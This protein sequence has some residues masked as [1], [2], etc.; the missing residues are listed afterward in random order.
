[1]L[2]GLSCFPIYPA[3]DPDFKSLPNCLM[4]FPGKRS[5]C[6]MRAYTVF[7]NLWRL[8]RSIWFGEADL[9]EC[10]ILATLH[11]DFMLASSISQRVSGF[12][13]SGIEVIT[14]RIEKNSV[15]NLFTSGP[16]YLLFLHTIMLFP[17]YLPGKYPTHSFK[18]ATCCYI[19]QGLSIL[20]LE[21]I[22]PFLCS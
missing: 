20:S 12:L 3:G 2:L 6:H 13:I 11:S 21:I 16:L 22:L 5:M 1:M 17:A 18:S 14:Y 10:W 4:W 8:I 9:N 7:S 19:P 15:D